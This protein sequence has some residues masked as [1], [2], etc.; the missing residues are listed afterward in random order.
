MEVT[1]TT[2]DLLITRSLSVGVASLPRKN[3]FSLSYFTLYKNSTYVWEA[4]IIS[5]YNS[6]RN[7]YLKML[8]MV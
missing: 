4:L 8:R 7:G 2:F 5:T 1:E 3:L 6:S